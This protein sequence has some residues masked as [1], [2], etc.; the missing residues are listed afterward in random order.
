MS[1]EIAR[2]VV[3]A[4]VTYQRLPRVAAA[5]AT[6][7]SAT[8]QYQPGA[9]VTVAIPAAAAAPAVTARTRPTLRSRCISADGRITRSAAA[10][11]HPTW[12]KS[13]A[14]PMAAAVA[15]AAPRRIP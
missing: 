5:P 11:D 4:G 9:D 13:K 8:T 1:I 12:S 7:T 15:P 6:A 14:N 2:S 3:N 10:H